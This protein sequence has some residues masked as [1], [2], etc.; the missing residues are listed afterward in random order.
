MRDEGGNETKGECP[1]ISFLLSIQV[2]THSQ[3]HLLASPSSPPSI[4][5]SEMLPS[6]ITFSKV[7]PL[8]GSC[9][10]SLLGEKG[11]LQGVAVILPQ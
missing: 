8:H 1:E 11:F 10:L 4:L 7:S 2:R 3:N 5:K 6:S 9:T